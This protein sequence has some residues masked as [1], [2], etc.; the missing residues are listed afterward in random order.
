M[1]LS[2]VYCKWF[3]FCLLGSFIDARLWGAQSED[4]LWLRKNFD[5][6]WLILLPGIFWIT[7]DIGWVVRNFWI[8]HYNGNVWIAWEMCKAHSLIVGLGMSVVWDL[9]YS[10]IEHKKWIVALPIWLT[11]PA[12]WRKTTNETDS[13]LV[14]GWTRRQMYVLDAVRVCILIASLVFI[15]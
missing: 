8:D 13:R 5:W 2:L 10:K 7:D 14:I 9:S 15:I 12:F 4:P 6:F 3:L 1:E 11:I